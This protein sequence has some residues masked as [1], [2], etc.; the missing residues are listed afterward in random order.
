M[1]LINTILWITAL[2]FITLRIS[3]PIRRLGD[4]MV[5]QAQEMKAVRESKG[6][7]RDTIGN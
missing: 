6:S 4:G 7:T 1:K 2:V 3:G 5:W